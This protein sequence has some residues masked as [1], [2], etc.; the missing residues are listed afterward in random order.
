MNDTCTFDLALIITVSDTSKNQPK[1]LDSDNQINV[2]RLIVILEK[3]IGREMSR[4]KHY[5][6]NVDIY[7][8]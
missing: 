1:R 6:T 8:I 4:Y 5:H 7:L 3:D 2:S